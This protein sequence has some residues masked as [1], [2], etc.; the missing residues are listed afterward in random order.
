MYHQVKAYI[1]KYHMLDKS[2]K[3]IAGVSGGADSI[4]LLFMLMKM[5]KEVD[6]ALT[7]VHIHHGLRGSSADAD[8]NYVKQI[9]EMHGV[10]LR[11]YHEDAG[12][13]AKRYGISLEEAGR[14]LRRQCFLATFEECNGTKIAL[15]H[16]QN[17][18]AETLLWNLC[19]GT[20]LKGLGGMAPKNGIWIRPL[21]C[22][23]RDNVESYLK[24][25]GISY[26]TDETNFEDDFTRNR[27]RNHILPYLQEN[28]NT[29]SVEHM[30]QTMEQMR[31]L[32]E[33]VQEQADSFRKESTQ[34]RGAEG[35]LLVKEKY[36]VIPK[37]LKPQILYGIIRQAVQKEKD[38][39]MVHLKMLDQLMTRQVGKEVHL[40]YGLVAQRCYEG[41]LFYQE[42][43]KC[44]GKEA[45]KEV[46]EE[47]EMK[48]NIFDKTI[49]MTIF[50]EIPY[51]KWFDY[52][53][54]KNTVQI[55]H[56]QPGDYISID[57]K[58][59]R[60]KLKQYF[61]N[62]KIP[63]SEREQIWVVADGPHIM[64]VVGYRQNQMY[65]VTDHT[66]RILEI[67]IDGGKK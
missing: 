10:E 49:D 52:D 61:I 67:E 18:N 24:E 16:H 7:A 58:G 23:K 50:P 31:L 33:Y 59:S 66:K 39:E 8:E 48:C 64:W 26:C 22:L 56:R 62:M 28:V 32:Q 29:R 40:P 6:F 9:C 19:R 54:I 60:Q 12:A 11:V 25:R 53:I 13:Y 2:D 30:A 4:C 3:V 38:I 17:D 5:Q 65:Q 57:S 35:L 1:D 21:L 34:D 51:T 37:A 20:G 41:L 27:I 14:E 46:A 47:V 45:S 36:G 42:D 55:R 15:A 43:Y 44:G 63:Q